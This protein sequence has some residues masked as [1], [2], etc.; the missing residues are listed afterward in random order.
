M[1]VDLTQNQMVALSW[2]AATIEVLTRKKLVDQSKIMGPRVYTEVQESVF[3][4]G[5]EG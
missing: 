2:V 5:P 4:G 1:I 3:D